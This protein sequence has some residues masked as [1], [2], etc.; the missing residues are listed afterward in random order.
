MGDIRS[1]AI[2]G[3]KTAGT[4]P[5]P[6][7]RPSES[8]TSTQCQ[9]PAVRT[10]PAYRTKLNGINAATLS[11]RRKEYRRSFT[12]I[13]ISLRSCT[14][15][16]T[17]RGRRRRRSP[18]FLPSADFLAYSWPRCARGADPGNATALRSMARLFTQPRNGQRQA[19]AGGRLSSMV[20]AYL[21]NADRGWDRVPARV[22]VSITFPR[23]AWLYSV[24]YRLS[25]VRRGTDA[26]VVQRSTN[27]WAER[28]W[29][30]R[31]TEHVIWSRQRRLIRSGS[32]YTVAPMGGFLTLMALFT[33]PDTFRA[34]CRR[35]R[36]P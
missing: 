26:T 3:W 4:L 1:R 19:G 36:V 30:T 6:G 32:G 13:P 22:Y 24:R 35:F 16:R 15:W 9:S 8:D 21:Q 33:A 14:C 7:D 2:A 17:I 5:P 27:T 23:R 25:R 10:H 20:P 29:T 28:I 31:S 11:P 12:P 18:F 34:R